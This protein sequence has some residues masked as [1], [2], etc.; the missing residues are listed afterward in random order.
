[1]QCDKLGAILNVHCNKEMIPLGSR[2]EGGAEVH[3]HNREQCFVV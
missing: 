1:M 2:C 3:N